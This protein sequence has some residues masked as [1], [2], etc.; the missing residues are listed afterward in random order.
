MDF[1]VKSQTREKERKKYTR[2]RS[3]CTIRIVNHKSQRPK[4]QHTSHAIYACRQSKY[5]YTHTHTHIH[6]QSGRDITREESRCKK[7]K[8][9]RALRSKRIDRETTKRSKMTFSR[10]SE[11]SNRREKTPASLFSSR[12]NRRMCN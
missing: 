1:L 6:R 8:V 5:V 12:S 10:T 2:R 11:R 3:L 4:E 7:K 9:A